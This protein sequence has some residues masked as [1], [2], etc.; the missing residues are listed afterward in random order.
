MLKSIQIIYEKGNTVK[1]KQKEKK[2]IRREECIY[3]LDGTIRKY[4]K[5]C[6]KKHKK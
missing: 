4:G 5:R 2:I 3:E 6:R 1:S